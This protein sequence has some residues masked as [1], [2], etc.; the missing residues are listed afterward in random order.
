MGVI[1]RFAAA[2]HPQESTAAAAAAAVGVRS[3]LG[4]VVAAAAAVP[5]AG[6]RSGSSKGLRWTEEDHKLWRKVW[7]LK[8]FEE[9]EEEVEESAADADDA[10]AA[11]APAGSEGQN[12]AFDDGKRKLYAPKALAD[13]VES[14]VGAVL[15]DS[16]S[17]SSRG[18][19]DHYNWAAAWQVVQRLLLSLR[20]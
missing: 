2:Q 3:G 19:A 20:S 9:G 18:N 8:S 4:G 16:S 11:A 7:V 6:P 14:L 12:S 10:A 5:A 15:V 17:S 13:I 1:R